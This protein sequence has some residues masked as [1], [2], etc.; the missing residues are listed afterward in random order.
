[1]IG[2]GTNDNSNGRDRKYAANDEAN[3]AGFFGHE[4]LYMWRKQNP[5]LQ[6]VGRMPY[7]IR[8]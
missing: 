4:P 5:R 1:M 2:A 6:S 7:P 8:E 3:G